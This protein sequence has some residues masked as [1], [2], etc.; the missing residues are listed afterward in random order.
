LFLEYVF[1]PTLGLNYLLYLRRNQW[2]PYKEV[3]E[4]QRDRLKSVLH[5]AYDYV[6]YYRR[7]FRKS[8]FKPGVVRDVEDIKKIPITTKQDVRNNF[9][10][11]MPFSTDLSRCIQTFTSGS[12]G[13]PLKNYK[14]VRDAV[15]DTA[16]KWYAFSECGVRLQ[17]RFVN[18][19]GRTRSLTLPTQI[20]ISSRLESRCIEELLKKIQPDVLYAPPCILEDICFCN[21]TGIN[22]RLIFSQAANLTERHRGLVRSVF[23]LEV[24]NTYGSAEFSRLAFECDEHSGL[25]MINDSAVM[26]FL[27]EDGEGV[28]SGECGEVIVT[29]LHNYIM[30]LIRYDLEDVACPTDER[31]GCGRSWPLIKQII[32]KTIELFTMPSGRKISPV[33]IL[34]IIINEARENIFVISQYQ[35]IQESKNKI[36]VKIVEGK[37]FDPNIIPRIKQGIEDVCYNMNEDVDVE[38][39]IV[40]I[41]PKESSGKRNI[42]L[43]LERQ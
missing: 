1:T 26:E 33:L 9:Y 18:I 39:N 2:R 10:D 4:I 23:G 21:E 3:R 7:L 13:I 17:D 22:P 25:H 12:T 28:S 32:G 16:A 42:I 8:G 11:L 34:P 30:P 27:D 20:N 19:A 38:I 36:K 5:H 15:K 6:P 14:S 41:I 29:G 24:F 40:D 37:D 31:C 43:K 35:V